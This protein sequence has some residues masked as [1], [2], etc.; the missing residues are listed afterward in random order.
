MDL[1]QEIAALGALPLALEGGGGAAELGLGLAVEGRGLVPV[2]SGQGVLALGLEG[3][4]VDPLG[5]GGALERLVDMPGPGLAPG[6]QQGPAV[7]G[8][9][10][11]PEAGSARWI[12]AAHG[13]E[14]M[15]VGVAAAVAGAAVVDGEIDDHAAGGELLLRE[16]RGPG[17]AGPRAPAR[18]A[19]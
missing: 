18:A 6:L 3:A 1:A 14:E 10:L 13:E 11:L 15:G 9:L 17:P 2:A 5:D 8:G 7:P 16:T 4:V 12:E 19:G